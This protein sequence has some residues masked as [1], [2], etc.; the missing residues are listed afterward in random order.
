MKWFGP[1]GVF[2]PAAGKHAKGAGAD[3]RPVKPPKGRP[4]PPEQT[5][6]EKKGLYRRK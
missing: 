3:P 6:N 4:A 2:G 5:P 1:G